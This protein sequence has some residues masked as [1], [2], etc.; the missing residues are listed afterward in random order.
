MLK[1]NSSSNILSLS[2]VL[3]VFMLSLNIYLEQNISVILLAIL[4]KKLF[5][6]LDISWYNIGNKYKDNKLVFTSIFNLVLYH[7]T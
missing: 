3:S 5:T 1:K 6:A 7:I 4:F 2:T